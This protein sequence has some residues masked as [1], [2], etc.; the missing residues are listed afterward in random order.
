MFDAN[1]AP[2]LHRHIHRLQ[3]YQNKFPHDPHH[4][5]VPS[6]ASKM[7]SEPMVRSA[8]IVLSCIKISPISK[9]TE[10]SYHLSLVNLE[11]HQLRPKWFLILWSVWRKPYTY[12]ALTLKPS[13]N[14]PKWGC[15]WATSPRC[16]ISFVQNNFQDYGI[17][18]AN[19]AS[20]LHWH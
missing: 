4:L 3:T 1:H 14:G 20:I 5:E 2:I 19:H 12:L 8:Q 16:S 11:Y 17:F 13:R 15:T 10:M 6:G 9:W 7:I 18:G